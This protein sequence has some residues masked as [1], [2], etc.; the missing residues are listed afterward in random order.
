MESPAPLAQNTESSPCLDDVHDGPVVDAVRR[1]SEIS[2][3]EVP[4]TPPMSPPQSEVGDDAIT[5]EA[6]HGLPNMVPEVAPSPEDLAQN[7]GAL[8]HAYEAMETEQVRPV[9]PPRPPLRHLED[10]RVHTERSGLLKLTDFEVKG[11]L[12]LHYYSVLHGCSTD[13]KGY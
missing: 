4:I 6:D 9:T 2:A 12:G 1:D 11:T 5:V 8:P 13:Y 7:A 10:E 3:H